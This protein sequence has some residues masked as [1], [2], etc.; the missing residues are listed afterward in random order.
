MLITK[1]SSF[2]EIEFILNNS[3]PDLLPKLL[4]DLNFLQFNFMQKDFSIQTNQYLVNHNPSYIELLMATQIPSLHFKLINHTSKLSQQQLFNLCFLLPT[5]IC[6]PILKKISIQTLCK[7]SEYISEYLLSLIFETKKNTEILILVPLI[8]NKKNVLKNL[9]HLPVNT[10]AN[11]LSFLEDDLILHINYTHISYEQKNFL[12][13]LINQ[14]GIEILSQ[15]P[16]IPPAIFILLYG[17]IDTRDLIINNFD[18][19]SF[20]SQKQIF[21]M[22]NKETI[23]EFIYNNFTIGQELL[24]NLKKEKEFEKILK[25]NESLNQVLNYSNVK[26]KGKKI[27]VIK[28]EILKYP[29]YF[30]NLQTIKTEI[31]IRNKIRAKEKTKI[32]LNKNKIKNLLINYFL[33]KYF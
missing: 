27:I 22:F 3:D 23:Y 25:N 19:L 10:F 12:M 4:N 30:Y 26:R 28:R 11:V 2:Q 29:E 7:N 20:D 24:I 31:A 15:S 17:L 6:L 21:E 32:L 9:L 5:N 13:Q 33:S 18:I 8:K 14:Y 1:E 16:L